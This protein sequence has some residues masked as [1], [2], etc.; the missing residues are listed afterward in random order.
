MAELKNKVA[1][2]TGGSRGIG[3][4]IALELA[5]NGVKIVINY[6]SN[7]AAADKMVAEIKEIGGDAICSTSRC[8]SYCR[9]RKT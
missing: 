8:F 6:N 2:V 5:K 3:S 9:C 1:I 7:S 4:A